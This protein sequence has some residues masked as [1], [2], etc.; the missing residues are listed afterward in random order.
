MTIIQIDTKNKALK[1]QFI[2]L[3]FQI[4]KNI[5]Q[6]V[7]PLS[8]EINQVLD[9]NRHPFYKH[10]EAAFF[11][12][13]DQDNVPVGRL[14]ILNNKNYNAYNK[15]NTAYFYLFESINDADVANNLFNAGINW[16]KSQGLNKIIGP[17]GFTVFDGIGMLV[18]G[19]EYRP[20]FGLPYNPPYYVDLIERLGFEPIDE[21]VSGYLNRETDFPKNI[22]EISKTIQERRDLRVAIYNNRKDIRQLI[23]HLK[24]MYND[25]LGG[26]TGN[27]PLTD[28][29]VEG[30]AE[31]MLWFADPKLIKIIYKQEK[32]VGFLFAY[33]DISA[34]VQRTKGQLFP[35]GW[36]DLFLEL[37]RTRWININGGG[38]VEGYRGLGGTAILF[39]EIYKS[40]V[41]S[42]YQHA[43]LVQVGVN[44]AN[45]Q[46]ELRNLGID[47]YKTHRLY[48][49]FI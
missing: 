4:Y 16:A 13:L 37:K 28:D 35:F 7:P 38:M 25:A 40:I 8:V 29:E 42:R 45:M 1:N 34:A 30:L 12:A 5:P 2:K 11:I 48:Q 47:F 44:N 33:P 18:K 21:L 6:W 19:F 14:A 27:V 3:P 17:K 15:E 23:P 36:L 31:Q 41:E 39:S 49:K 26:T 46:R 22:H 10:S 24:D 32:P 20:A 9:E 43:E